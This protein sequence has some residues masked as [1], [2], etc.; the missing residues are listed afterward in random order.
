MTIG[1]QI[2]ARR[3]K[4]RMTLMDLADKTD[5]DPSPLSRIEKGYVNP[6]LDTLEII[7]DALGC[8]IV[9]VEKGAEE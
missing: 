5:M 2:R 1:E 8:N 3:K 4:L 9:I 6:R 7:L